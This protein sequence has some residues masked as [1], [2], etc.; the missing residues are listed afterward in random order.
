MIDHTPPVQWLAP[1]PLWAAHLNAEPAAMRRPSVLRFASDTFMDDIAALLAS[2]PAA[3]AGQIVRGESFR[4]RPLGSPAGWVPPPLPVPKLY[5]PAHGH[6]SL[7]AAS[8]VCRIPGLPDRTLNVQA[9]ERTGFVMR[10]LASDGTEYAWATEGTSAHGWRHIPAGAERAVHEDE[11]QLPLFPVVFAEEGRR[12]RLLMGLIPTASRETFQAA[13]ELSPLVVPPSDPREEELRERVI[14]VLEDLRAASSAREQAIEGSLFILLDLADFLI[15]HRSS[16]WTPVIAGTAAVP[17]SQPGHAL[18]QQLLL[19]STGAPGNVTW[20]TAIRNTWAQR[21]RITRG[22]ATSPSLPYDL[23]A[24]GISLDDLARNAMAA[25][26]TWTPPAEPPAEVPVPK[27]P[28][29]GAVRYG[30]RMVFERPGCGPLQPPVVSERTAPFLLAS[31]FDSDAPARSIRI[32]LPIDTSTAGLR[33]YRNNVGFVI[34]DRLKQQIGCVRDATSALKGDISCGQPIDIGL[35]CSFS[36]PIITICALVLLMVM[37]IAL[38][39]VF[40]WLP[41]FRICVP[42]SI[43]ARA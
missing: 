8:L 38:N 24:T 43:R 26:G 42:A 13:P 27:L 9:G 21:D 10:R 12:R 32:S 6:F 22:E 1:S 31:F 14:D 30:L 5:Q 34:S 35:I 25:I 39:I 19:A 40:W 41:F 4:A 28:T 7:I 36:I 2:N 33:A 15:T 16:V 23:R 29:G 3:L 18:Y 20:L 37:V 11:E 17:S